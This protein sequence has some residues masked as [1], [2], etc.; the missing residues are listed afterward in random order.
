LTDQLERP[1]VVDDLN[2]AL[3]SRPGADRAFVFVQAECAPEQ[4]VAEVDWVMSLQ[5]GLALRGIVARA[6]VEDPCATSTLLRAYADRPLVVGV[7]RLLQS[8]REGFATSELFRRGAQMVAVAGLTFDACVRPTQLCEVAELA[9]A[10]PELTIVLD[11]LGN[12]PTT[13]VSTPDLRQWMKSMRTLA[14]RPNVVCKLSGFSSTASVDSLWR[15][16]DTALDAF[17]ASRLLFGSDWPISDANLTG[18]ELIE[19]WLDSRV[20]EQDK[21]EVLAGNAKRIY[22][23]VEHPGGGYE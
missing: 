17:G 16:F 15:T 14:A 20:D 5:D 7:R 21:A 22:R 19:T 3:A 11:H 10:V 1:F 6:P 8:E 13:A 9:A 23:L 12:P 4:S 2:A 18:L